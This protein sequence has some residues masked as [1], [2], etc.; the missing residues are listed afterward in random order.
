V[1]ELVVGG[2]AALVVLV[3]VGVIILAACGEDRS[4]AVSES[5][6]SIDDYLADVR[7]RSDE[8]HLSETQGFP[9]IPPDHWWDA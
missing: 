8:L 6:T 2:F 9:A 3:I 5:M 1:A 4:N 7:K